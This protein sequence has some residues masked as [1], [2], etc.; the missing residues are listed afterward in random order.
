MTAPDREERG[1]WGVWV[2][3]VSNGAPCG[4]IRRLRLDSGSGFDGAAQAFEFFFRD[5]AFGQ[6]YP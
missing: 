1:A 5:G 6:P 2:V 4:V 3:Y